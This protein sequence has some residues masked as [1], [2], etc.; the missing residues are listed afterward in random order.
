[1]AAKDANGKSDPY[2]IFT[3]QGK[4]YKTTTIY[5]NLNPIWE[6]ASFNLGEFSTAESLEVQVWDKDRLSKDDFMGRVIIPLKDVAEVGNHE[7][8]HLLEQRE[9]KNEEVSGELLLLFETRNL[10]HSP[11]T[12]G[13][14]LEQLA[15]R[16]SMDI[17]Q[18]VSTLLEFIAGCP[19]EHQLFKIPVSPESLSTLKSTIDAGGAIAWSRDTPERSVHHAAGLLKLFLRELP[20]PVMTRDLL[21]KIVDA[22]REDESSSSVVAKTKFIFAILPDV[23][24]LLL[25]A[26]LRA[27]DALHHKDPKAL[28]AALAA[29]LVGSDVDAAALLHIET[30]FARTFAN[31]DL[32]LPKPLAHNLE[33]HLHLL[34]SSD[35]TSTLLPGENAVTDLD[36]DSEAYKLFISYDIDKSN[37]IDRHEFG[38]FYTEFV[39]SL[40]RK[41]PSHRALRRIWTEVDADGNDEVSWEEFAKW[42][43]SLQSAR[44][45]TMNLGPA[46]S[47]Y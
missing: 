38:I 15:K 35:S 40:G 44:P 18:F 36:V 39:K 29:D 5:K 16:D 20:V 34:A 14:D 28:A 42:W 10:G 23:H 21:R 9:K 6:K 33:E 1:M 24:I 37:T 26:I 8:W 47:S 45:K 41:P 22:G 32:Y 11:P 19:D 2:V 17:P 27:I 25:S 3:W 13:V 46:S 43:R 7:K 12:F 4:T 30:F 31:V